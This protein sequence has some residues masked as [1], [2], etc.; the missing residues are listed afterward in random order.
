MGSGLG[1]IYEPGNGVIGDAFNGKPAARQPSGRSGKSTPAKGTLEANIESA[2]KEFGLGKDGFFGEPG[3]KGGIRQIESENPEQDAKRLYDL[4]SKDGT[5][6]LI[7][8]GKGA[9][10]R[11]ND[12]TCIS[13][14]IETRAPGSPAV[15]ISRSAIPSLKDQKIHFIKKR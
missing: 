10:T 7:S 5:K 9:K 3:S 14:R 13:F 6:G 8:G 11:L 15:Q 1:S 4:L 12:G 2:K